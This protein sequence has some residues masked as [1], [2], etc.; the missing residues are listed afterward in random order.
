MIVSDAS[1]IVSG[2]ENDGPARL[3]LAAGDLQVPHLVD[4]EVVHA[5]RGR[6]RGGLLEAETAKERMDA[7]LRVGVRRHSVIPLIDRMWELRDNLSAYDA[8][9]VAL[10][11]SLRCPLATGDRRI[12]RA[13]GLR[14]EMIVIDH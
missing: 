13:P 3:L 11:E 12:A 9:Y 4:H 8:G 7:W 1:V 10:A 5:F 2:L 14:C 6:V